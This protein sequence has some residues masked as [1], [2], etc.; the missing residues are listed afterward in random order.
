MECLF[1][2]ASKICYLVSFILRLFLHFMCLF[3]YFIGFKNQRG[4]I[5]GCGSFGVNLKELEAKKGI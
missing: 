3:N 2:I 1:F 4:R 5:M